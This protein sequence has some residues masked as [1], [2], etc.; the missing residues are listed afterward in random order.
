MK[1]D[2][3][4]RFPGVAAQVDEQ[5]DAV[6]GDSLRERNIVHAANRNEMIDRATIL[7]GDVVLHRRVQV[8]VA[9][10]FE[11][12]FVVVA[13]QS[14]DEVIDRVHPEVGGQIADA[15]LRLRLHR[16]LMIDAEPVMSDVV[17]VGCR[18]PFRDVADLLIG[19]RRYGQ[20]R[21]QAMAGRSHLAVVDRAPLE[22]VG[23]QGFLDLPLA[24]LG[25]LAEQR[26]QGYVRLRLLENL[27]GQVEH[28]LVSAHH[29]EV[30]QDVVENG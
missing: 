22:K 6:R 18:D 8:R 24:D 20:H 3:E 27:F 11:E 5:M 21:Q 10:D 14:G 19:N 23:Q 1:H 25:G 4:S 17:P 12:L 2:A 9:I 30:G 29:P 15:Q 28:V 26:G 16:A 13:E 7:C